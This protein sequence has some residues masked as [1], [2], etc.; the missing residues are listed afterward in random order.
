MTGVEIVQIAC[1][2]VMIIVAGGIAWNRL[3]LGRSFGVRAT[4]YLAVGL[5]IPAIVVLATASKIQSETAVAILAALTGYLF[6]SIAK[7]DDRDDR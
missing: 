2:L 1:G 3:K 5:I 6:S 4:Q 7:F